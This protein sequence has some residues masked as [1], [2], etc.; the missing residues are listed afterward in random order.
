MNTTKVT[1]AKIIS[2]GRRYVTLP[3]HITVTAGV[4][5]PVMSHRG[6]GSHKVYDVVVVSERMSISSTID[7]LIVV[8]VHGNLYASLVHGSAALAMVHFSSIVS[9]WAAL[10]QAGPHVVLADKVFDDLIAV[11]AKT[12]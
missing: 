7:H 11:P 3:R 5:I 9:G 10:M 1:L 4:E 12:E 6:D 2:S 8:D